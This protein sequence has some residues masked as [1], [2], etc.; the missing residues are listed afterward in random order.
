MAVYLYHENQLMM[1]IK[2]AFVFPEELIVKHEL[3]HHCFYP[4]AKYKE[5]H[6]HTHTGKIELGKPHQ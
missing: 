2:V 5:L 6:T 3:A 4:N 1:Q